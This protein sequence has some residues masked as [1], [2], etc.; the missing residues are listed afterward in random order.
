[1]PMPPSR[2]DGGFSAAVARADAAVTVLDDPADIENVAI[3]RWLKAH[4]IGWAH[5]HHF[6]VGSAVLPPLWR[7]KTV[8]FPTVTAAGQFLNQFRHHPAALAVLHKAMSPLATTPA[9][10]VREK[11]FLDAAALALASGT[12]W[13]VEIRRM[14][15]P[16]VDDASPSVFTAL[17]QKYGTSIDFVFLSDMEGGQYTRGY[18]PF[19]DAGIVDGRSGMSIA[20]AFDITQK[21]SRQLLDLGLSAGLTARLD[22]FTHQPDDPERGPFAGKTKVQAAAIVI[23]KGGVPTITKAEAD[24]I[25]T[26]VISEHVAQTLTTWDRLKQSNVPA[27]RSLPGGWQTVLLCR[28]YQQGPGFPDTTVGKPFYDAAKAG[29][30][31]DAV[32]ELRKYTRYADRIQKEAA[33]LRQAMPPPVPVSPADPP[34]P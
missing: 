2:D 23:Q 9:P 24:E 16:R 19:T 14:P 31:Q 34:K 27:F 5:R 1:M 13:V 6:A 18:I 7:R 12:L 25:D 4:A 33:L 32:D 28:T 17:N 8:P 20:T 29:R 21:N 22:P 11:V 3:F 15:K 30:W 10:M 26:A